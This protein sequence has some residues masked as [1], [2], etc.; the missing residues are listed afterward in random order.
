MSFV[1]MPSVPIPIDMAPSVM[2]AEAMGLE[3]D[4]SNEA[5]RET[6]PLVN[7]V[8]EKFQRSR[9]KRR[10]DED[11][12]LECYRNYRGV[13]APTTQF[14]ST[15]KSRAFIKI[16][17]TKCQ[18][19][20]AQIVD[21]LFAGNKFP[22]GVQAPR[23]ALTVED[24]V[25]FDPNDPTG[26]MGG[27][28][29]GQPAPDQNLRSSPSMA[30]HIAK[31]FGPKKELLKKVEDKLKSGVGMTPS[32]ITFEPIKEAALK[33]E[34]KIQDQLDEANAATSLRSLV[35]E[36]C[37]FGTGIYKGP[38]A[39][40]KE[41]PKWDES[42][43][44]T[45]SSFTIPDM[46][47]VSLWNAYPDADARNMQ[48][49]EWF[50]ERH[51]LSRTQLRAL[52][53]RPMFRKT[54]IEK[55][56][57][58]GPNYVN[59]WW[60]HQLTDNSFA[61]AWE[62]WE[63]LE[64]WGIID[65]ELADEC[66]LK[67]PKEYKGYDEF[68]INAWISGDFVIRLVINPFKPS[69]IPYHAVPYE[70]NPYSFFGIG[71]AENMMD[72][73]L[74]MN[75]FMRMA[76]DNAALSGNVVY[77]VN[78]DIL[79][80]GQELEIYPGKVFRRTMSGNPQDKAIDSIKFD[81]VTQENMIL[82]DK[83]R[84]LADESTGMPSFSHGMTDVMSTGKTAAGMSMLMG[85]AAQNIKAVVRNIDD[86]LLAPLGKDLFSFNMQFNFDKDF[87]GDVTVVA[88]G[89]ESL[90][91][92]EVRSQKL[93]QLGQFAGAN[94]M[95]SPLVKWDYILRE[96]AASLDLDEDLVVNDPRGAQIQAVQMAA[97]QA[98]LAPP[99]PPGQAGQAAAAQGNGQVAG[100]SPPGPQDPTG[101]GN[102]NIAPGAAPSP[103]QAGFS[104][105][106]E[107]RSG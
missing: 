92:N 25:N 74:L 70:I 15:E 98:Q 57:E 9:D 56:I 79:A 45:P 32:A 90:M 19:A 87:I 41:Y 65:R 40:T 95:I 43:A 27:Q 64:Y 47:Y 39:M 29:P 67:I 84:Q 51:R 85:A 105:N 78:E 101:N 69:R 16:T 44:Y 30:P 8:T 18:A 100:G 42:G 46:D 81:N 83:A 10:T 62:R 12:W 97:F 54:N 14:T 11:R 22:I 21:V 2:E 28:P 77:S 73:Q 20:F 36:L 13:H 93:L 96:Y 52:N 48:E 35:S 53:K 3:E 61:T 71:V 106:K 102:G 104:G 60:E 72:S 103:D 86:Y 31:I 68:Q 107:Q 59:Q 89:T 24:A 80:P 99:G 82:F 6:D 91:R 26:N 1:E 76:V 88:Q 17:K 38:F 5:L 23:V 4:T 34:R 55:L 66:K 49:A 58:D 50:I 37:I 94:P 7:Y 63:I 75:G 33:M